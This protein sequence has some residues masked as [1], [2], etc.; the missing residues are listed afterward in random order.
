MSTKSKQDRADST[1]ARALRP[2]Q[3][4]VP[5]ERL[6][7]ER[8]QLAAEP[9]SDRLKA[10][11]VQL[12]LEAMPGWRLAAGGRVLDRLRQF[13]SPRVAAEFTGY[14]AQ[15]AAQVRQPIAVELGGKRVTLTLWARGGSGLSEATLDFAQALG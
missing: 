1:V 7:A 3:Q 9:F 10:E 5:E 2:R 4:E 15:F 6:K 11:R 12:R 13:P 14:V 8:V